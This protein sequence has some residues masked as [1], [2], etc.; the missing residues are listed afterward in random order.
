MLLCGNELSVRGNGVAQCGMPAT[1]VGLALRPCGISLSL[2]GTVMMLNGTSH[3]LVELRPLSWTNH[4]GRSKVVL[5]SD[6]WP[7]L[8]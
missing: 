6:A 4:K 5:W 2:C 1:L 8:H 7:T 3:T